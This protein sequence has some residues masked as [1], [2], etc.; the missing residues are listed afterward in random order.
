M[1]LKYVGINKKGRA[2]WAELDLADGFHPEGRILEQWQVDHYKPFVEQI[3]QRI[4]RK[5][6]KNELGTIE[7]LSSS[8]QRTVDKIMGII[9]AAYY[10]GKE[11]K[12]CGKDSEGS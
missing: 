8:D 9:N 5:L 11:S 6:E 2:E 1:N 12:E 10:H 3:E 7:W 4:G